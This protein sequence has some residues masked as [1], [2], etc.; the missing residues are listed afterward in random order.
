MQSDATWTHSSEI[1]IRSVADE[2]QNEQNEEEAATMKMNFLH[3]S[4]VLMKQTAVRWKHSRQ[5]VGNR[6][7]SKQNEMNEKMEESEISKKRIKERN[8]KKAQR[9]SYKRTNERHKRQSF[10]LSK[11]VNTFCV[12]LSPTVKQKKEE[13]SVRH[14]RWMKWVHAFKRIKLFWPTPPSNTKD[15][16]LESLN[17]FLLKLN[18]PHFQSV[19]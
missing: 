5:F 17:S 15:Y 6:K 12:V 9:I 14:L 3:F 2:N 10:F 11:L 7:L 1:K 16:C 4:L 18:L 19:A 8:K 13:N